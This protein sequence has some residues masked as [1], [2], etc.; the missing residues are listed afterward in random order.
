MNS[1]P[2]RSFWR[3]LVDHEGFADQWFLDEPITAG[4]EEID[5]REFTEGVPYPGPR[6]AVVP[7]GNSGR[8]LAFS[9]GAFDMPVVSTAI[10]DVIFRIA[11]DDVECFPINVPGSK[12]TYVILN[13]ICALDCLDEEKS[14]FTR[15]TKEDERPDRLGQY[16]VISTIRVD[17]SRA[18]DHHIFRIKD[19]PLALLLSN[20]L[21]NALADIPDLGVVFSQAS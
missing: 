17:P 14:E 7:V 3:V 8:E 10:A 6:P 12:G 9:F 4:G 16:H 20:T 1:V 2:Q 11:P 13:V 18:Q 19:W 15:W 21:K 5:A